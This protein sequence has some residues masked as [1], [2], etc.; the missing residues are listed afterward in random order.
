MAFRPSLLS[1]VL[2]FDANS[3]A[4][5]RDDYGGRI[6]HSNSVASAAS[7]PDATNA[8]LAQLLDL[9]ERCAGSLSAL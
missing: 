7:G 2:V 9:R 8:L 1:T 6:V 3:I 4:R 5:R